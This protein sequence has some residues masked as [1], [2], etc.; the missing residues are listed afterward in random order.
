MV[1]PVV[2]WDDSVD[3]GEELVSRRQMLAIAGGALH[4]AQQAGARLVALDCLYMYG[5]P[6]GPMREDSPL[7][8]C[9]RKGELRVKLA[10]LRLAF[11]L[12]ND[13]EFLHMPYVEMNVNILELFE[14]GKLQ[15]ASAALNEYLVHSERI[16]LAA[17]EPE[18][19]PV[20]LVYSEGR[21]AAAKVRAF[22]DFAAQQL[23]AH[24]ALNPAAD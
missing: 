18:P 3:S 12:L 19:I 2:H 1:K 9:S 4:G 24:P 23:R 15:E 17:Y 22:V 21:S 16:V 7:N 14:A 5:R 11:G 13:P 8:P 20:Y 10:E 6:E